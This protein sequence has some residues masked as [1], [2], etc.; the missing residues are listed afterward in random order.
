MSHNAGMITHEIVGGE[1]M[2][3]VIITMAAVPHACPF[4]PFDIDARKS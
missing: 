2:Q 4:P 3:A 1:D